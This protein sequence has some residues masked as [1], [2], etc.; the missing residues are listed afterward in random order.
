MPLFW[1]DVARVDVVIHLDPA[2]EGL[3]RGLNQ[4]LDGL[5]AAVSH[6]EVKVAGE[7]EALRARVEENTQVDQSAILLLNELKKKLDEA[8]ASGNMA[9]VQA[10]SDSLGA[11]SGQ[12]AAAVAANT[13]SEPPPPEV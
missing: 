12:L 6:L 11:S 1:P 2:V 10:L 13:P 3:L 4:K 7:L 5:V 8:I 9:E